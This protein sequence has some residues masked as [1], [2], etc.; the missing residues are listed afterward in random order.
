MQ[1]NKTSL[2]PRK[3]FKKKTLKVYKGPSSDPFS[4]AISCALNSLQMHH[5]A[6]SLDTTLQTRLCHSATLHLEGSRCLQKN[7][8]LHRCGMVLSVL[9][10]EKRTI[11]M[12]F[13]RLVHHQYSFPS[14]LVHTFRTC[15]EF[16]SS[17]FQMYLYWSKLPRQHWTS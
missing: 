12:E 17:F 9:I 13:R 3:W 6:F 5:S 7:V 2:V 11:E 4:I 1:H 16:S 8:S 15:I 10:V 14:V